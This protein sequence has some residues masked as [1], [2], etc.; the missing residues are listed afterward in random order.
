MLV[1]EK[2]KKK[3]LK[4]VCS[5]DNINLIKS[6]PRSVIQKVNKLTQGEN[7]ALSCD[8]TAIPRD[9]DDKEEIKQ[10]EGRDSDVTMQSTATSAAHASAQSV[11]KSDMPTVISDAEMSN[12]EG[13]TKKPVEAEE[14]KEMED[15]MAKVPHSFLIY[16]NLISSIYDNSD[17]VV[18]YDE[19]MKEHYTEVP[20]HQVQKFVPNE[21]YRLVHN[22]NQLFLAEK[23]VFCTPFFK[24]SAQMIEQYLNS[25]D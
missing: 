5:E 22:D 14:D 23:Q 12:S 16:P 21:Y 17:T 10:E 2:A 20:F 15:F 19:E 6:Q 11:S 9:I 18:K 25:I 7:S 1:Y 4:I 8:G 24:T 13:I 3:P